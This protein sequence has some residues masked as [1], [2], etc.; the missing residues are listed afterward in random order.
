[1]LGL[2]STRVLFGGDDLLTGAH[3]GGRI[4]GSLVVA[5]NRLRFVATDGAL[6]TDTYQVLLHS[7]TDGLRAADGGAILDGEFSGVFPSGDGIAGGDFVFSFTVA[8]A[9]SLVVGI[10]NFARGPGQAVNLLTS[11][12]GSSVDSGLPI[13]LSTSAG[14][15]SLTVTVEFDPALLHV[16]DVRLGPDAPEGS[17]VT[18]N[19][20][21]AGQATIAFFALDPLP[22]G[23]TR[24]IVLDAD[25]PATAP[26]ASAQAI[27]L[28]RVDVNAGA[29]SATAA[30][31][32]HV[33]AF[34]GDTNRNL[35][36]DAEDARLIARVGVA[37]DSGFAVDPP[38]AETTSPTRLLY[39]T[40]D[41]R[42][43][44]DVTGDGTLSA[45]DASDVLRRVVGLSTPG[46]PALPDN[47]A[48][49][50]IILSPNTVDADA[51]QGTTVGALTAVDPDEGDSHTFT[52][53]SGDG[54][55]DNA[56]F[57]IDGNTLTTVATL[58]IDVQSTYH[59]RVRATDAEGLS[60][61]R[62]LTIQVVE[63]N[64]A[65]TAVTLSETT[66]PENAPLGTLVGEL[67]AVDPNSSDTHTFLLV[68][69]EGDPDNGAFLIDVPSTCDS[70]RTGLRD[71]E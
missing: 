7:A 3:P 58:D 23:S 36:Y 10:P 53:V 31:G 47:I 2:S 26:Y 61:E 49:Q 21:T 60:V 42:I 43:I 32:L 59:I 4:Q 67:D 16:S 28:T 11:P 1:M 66:V 13:A 27:R 15:T 50:D 33:V 25:V 52:F 45:L 37:V 65:P 29:L 54:D 56:A 51:A 34:P 41:P 40:I 24:I 9:A 22:E 19:L 48:P 69:G 6:P 20:S 30:D 39:P 38:H 18:V 17:Q 46:I 44:A 57:A 14:V 63:P 55:V 62:A 5:E 35:R 64:R 68:S 8:D 71:A 12:D 70:H